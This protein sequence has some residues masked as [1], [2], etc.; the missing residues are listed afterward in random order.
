MLFGTS[1]TLADGKNAEKIW[2]NACAHIQ[3]ELSEQSFKTW[4]EPISLAS[5]DGTKATLC[6]PDKFYGEWITDHFKEIIRDALSKEVS[7]R[8]DL[9]FAVT[10]PS[11]A[12]RPPSP[13]PAPKAEPAAMGDVL[14][15]SAYTFENFV[16][17]PGNQFAHA[18]ALAVAEH[19]GKNYNPLFIH[20]S[21]GLGKTHLMQAV[22]H[23]V[24][25]KNPEK[26]VYCT[27]SEKFTNQ[28]ISAIQTRSTQKFRA[29]YRSV[30][31]LLIDDIHFIAGKEAT[32][33]EFFHTFNALYDAH[34]QI[35]VVSDRPP[36][37]IPGL[38]ER[39][40]SRFGWGL[41]TDM[42]LPDFETRVAILKKKMER[43][44]V[45][46]P[47][48][49]VHFIAKHIRSNIRELEGAL[50]RVVAF[51]SMTGVPIDLS[52][53]QQVLKDSFKEEKSK[54]T[55]DLIQRKVAEY[56]NMKATDLRNKSRMRSVAVPRQIA[57]YL[58][59]ELTPHSLLEIG[60][61][62]GGRN[63][64]TVLHSYQ[65]IKGDAEKEGFVKDA[66]ET[67]LNRIHSD[68]Y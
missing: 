15:N 29:R 65:K 66:L 26:S 23:A 51:A 57:I 6:V 47:E 27:S 39:L 24:L 3:K 28:L 62:F 42:Q 58:I 13:A 18:A 61:Y 21:V 64:A 32:Q 54:I 8:P 17:G 25:K 12:P 45:L 33:E 56:F 63:H 52:L 11:P 40:V 4:I 41:V 67:I 38:E 31:L 43:E 59:R 7:F 1:K 34:K 16:V 20:G 2:K 68:S 9:G 44:T 37:D 5:L 48:D 55:I 30:D 22:A 10:A 46:V 35:V 50:V 14:L 53:A 36:R 19:P 60:D 49:V